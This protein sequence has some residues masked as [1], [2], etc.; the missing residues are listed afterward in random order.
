MKCFN[1]HEKD[2]VGVCKFCLKGICPECLTD[3][4]QGIACK[5]NHEA[6]VEFLGKLI[7]Q[8]KQTIKLQPRSVLIGNLSWLFMGIIFI[9]FGIYAF[10]DFLLV[11][12]AF[13][14]AYW[15]YLF[16]YNKSIFKKLRDNE[17]K[18]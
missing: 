18:D 3:L 16:I 17:L 8:S 14:F 13:C 6:D 5:N 10:N 4:D 12:G 1:H 2:A 15:C 7:N 11:F 9:G